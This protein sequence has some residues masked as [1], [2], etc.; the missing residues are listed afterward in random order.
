MAASIILAAGWFGAAHSEESAKTTVDVDASAYVGVSYIDN[1]F[2]TANDKVND[3]V[4]VMAPEIGV[5]L[6]NERFSAGIGGGA[7]I[8]VFDEND[9]E[10]YADFVLRGSGEAKV[11]DAFTIFA[12]MDHAWEHEE[13][14]SPEDV[15]G[16]EPTEYR[17]ASGYAG[18]RAEF[19][20]VKANVGANL[21]RYDFDDVS[22]AG[23]GEIDNDDRDRLQSEFGARVGYMVTPDWE[24]FVQGIYDRRDY[25]DRVDNFGFDRDSDGVQAAVGVKGR[26]ASLSGEAKIG[27]IHHAFDDPAFDRVT[28][29][30]FD[31]DF[32][33]RA[34]PGLRISGFIDR[35]LEETTLPGAS[36][37]VSTA[38][39]LRL[40]KRVAADLDA[41]AFYAMSANDYNDDNRD[42]YLT[43]A[44]FGVRYFFMPNLFVGA[45]YT[46]SQRLSD[47]AGAQ[48]DRHTVMARIG[49]QLDDAYGDGDPLATAG[50]NGL[51]LGLQAGHGALL[52]SNDGPRGGGGGEV[53]AEFGESGFSGGPFL[54][55]RALIE[56]FLLGVEVDGSLADKEWFHDADRD[57]GVKKKNEIGLSAIAG[58]RAQGD[59]LFYGRFG[60]VSAEFE[61]AYRRGGDVTELEDREYGIAGGLGAEFPIA[62]GFSA[63]MEYV[64]AAYRDYDI[65]APLGAA[66]DN[67]ANIET[68]ARIGLVY[69]F[70]AEEREAPPPVDF[71]G[72]YAGIQ[73]GHGT[74]ESDNTGPRPNAAAPAFTFDAVRSGQGFTGGVFAGYGQQFGDFYLGGEAEAEIS[75][76]DWN[77]ERDPEGRIYSVDKEWTLGASAR[78][79]YVLNDAVLLYGRA[80]VVGTQFKTSYDVGANSVDQNDFKPGVRIGGGAEIAVGADTSIRLDYTRTEYKGYSVD[81]NSG[82][83]TFDNAENL[84]RVGVSHRF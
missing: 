72:F 57:F 74:I 5:S 6:R 42:D 80:G 45:D 13:R 79:G 49:A 22:A 54:G 69:A 56:D 58:M 77:I 76:A 1:I 38:A 55:Y 62:G 82:V 4:T 84:F 47:E 73:A 39:G 36:S 7:Q 33:W 26:R 21:R 44:G 43:D 18:V 24:A 60:V 67:F 19:G 64:V 37:Y 63:R 12:G 8:G 10:D 66:D 75:D 27:V 59:S 17:D 2:S 50:P 46:F 52:T 83:D 51:Y 32:L 71:S 11:S 28:T 30:D 35:T 78:A 65:G 61:S 23:G 48:Y 81:Y 15:N 70:G 14:S 41:H 9:S 3:V 16:Q 25:Q 68:T 40:A 31:A 53:T 34:G 29:L 20:K